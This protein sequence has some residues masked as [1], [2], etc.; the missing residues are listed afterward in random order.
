MRKMKFK[1][2][3]DQYIEIPTR[4]IQNSTFLKLQESHND[5]ISFTPTNEI[6]ISHICCNLAT[7]EKFINC[8]EV[9][10]F[11]L[12]DI[13][14][15]VSYIHLCNYLDLKEEF[16]HNLINLEEITVSN[17]ISLIPF[18]YSLLTYNFVN[19]CLDIAKKFK[20]KH[21]YFPISYYR[22]RKQFKALLVQK[23]YE[24]KT[25]ILP[26][27]KTSSWDNFLGMPLSEV[28]PNEGFFRKVKVYPFRK[29][30]N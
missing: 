10:R 28:F 18:L 19:I 27:P 3:E 8:I 16:V 7:V 26:Y 14:P 15:L 6:D 30:S 1:V 20:I 2:D 13:Y 24:R 17:I 12:Y 25:V 23:Y 11:D 22:F 29:K 9:G 4:L 21:V 5:S